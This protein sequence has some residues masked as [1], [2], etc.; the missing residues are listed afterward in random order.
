MSTT[1]GKLREYETILILNPDLSDEAASELLERLRGILTKMKA[2]LLQEDGWG[3]RKMAFEAKKHP[4]G[5]YRI[6]HYAG[7]VGVVQELERTMRNAEH[8]LRFTTNLLGEVTDIEAKRAEVEK[9]L[10][11]RQAKAKAKAEAER[12]ER[13]EATEAASAPR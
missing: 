3:K 4:R 6:L 2:E 10:Q 7:P 13:E 9:M 11:E 1:L 12:R 5:D 8:V